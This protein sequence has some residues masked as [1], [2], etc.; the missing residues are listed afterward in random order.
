MTN[1][2][3]LKKIQFIENYKSELNISASCRAIGVSRQT[4]YE[5]ISKDK[6]FKREVNEIEESII[7]DVESK[8]MEKIKSGDLGAIIFFL[9]TKG[10]KRGYTER[11]E[12]ENKE[13]NESQIKIY[14]PKKE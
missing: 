5:W 13:A 11:I 9:K 6:K 4:F 2:T 1:K 10:K 8:L 14:L 12:T 7:D 3:K